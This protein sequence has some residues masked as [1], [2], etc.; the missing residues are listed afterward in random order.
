M[1][2]FHPPLA[3]LLLAFAAGILAETYP[4]AWARECV[5]TDSLRRLILADVEVR[6]CGRVARPHCL[7]ATTP[8]TRLGASLRLNHFAGV[9][10]EGLR[11][12]PLAVIG[13]GTVVGRS[14][15]HVTGVPLI[16]SGS[17]ATNRSMYRPYNGA[18]NLALARP[19]TAFPGLARRRGACH[20]QT[21]ALRDRPRRHPRP[22]LYWD[23]PRLCSRSPGASRCVTTTPQRSL[24][25]GALPRAKGA[26]RGGMCW[27]QRSLQSDTLWSLSN[28]SGARGQRSTNSSAPADPRGRLI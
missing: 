10:A 3:V 12:K 4:S 23:F 22:P 28:K 24:P 21:V 25:D 27:D 6:Q 15:R 13:T 9:W 26:K 19:E 5:S 20:Q 7:S 8:H 14:W 2:R 1:R 17:A 16:S 18:A 11:R